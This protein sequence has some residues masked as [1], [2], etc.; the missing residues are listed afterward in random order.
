MESTQQKEMVKNSIWLQRIEKS[1]QELVIFSQWHNVLPFQLDISV[2]VLSSKKKKKKTVQCL[3]TFFK[4][5]K[6]VNK[7]FQFLVCPKH[8]ILSAFSSVY[9][10]EKKILNHL[11]VSTNILNIV[12]LCLQIKNIPL[13]FKASRIFF[14]LGR[15]VTYV[16]KYIQKNKLEKT[17]LNGKKLSIVMDKFNV[18]I[19]KSI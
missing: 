13:S 6:Y 12:S 11:L 4:I 10:R 14:V 17:L 3:V 8:K 5:D 15:H 18:F 2:L 1:F 16:N 19:T 7:F 9:Y